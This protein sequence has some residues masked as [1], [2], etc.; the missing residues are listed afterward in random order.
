MTNLTHVVLALAVLALPAL[1]GGLIAAL[2]VVEDVPTA[3][4]SLNA[5]VLYIAFP[6]LIAHAL[7]AE[8]FVMPTSAAFW[9][10]VP[11]AQVFVLACCLAI[12]GG[13]R[14]SVALTGLW[15]NIGY[16]GLPLVLATF[17]EAAAGR[18]AIWASLYIAI[19]VSLG[20]AMLRGGSMSAVRDALKHPLVVSLPVGLLLRLLPGRQVE[21]ADA[22]L[23]PLSASAAPVALFLLGLHIYDRR[24]ELSGITGLW[25]HVGMKLVLAPALTLAVAVGFHL[26]A[27]LSAADIPPLVTLAATPVAIT[28]LVV[29]SEAGRAVTVVASSIFVSSLLA[30]FTLVPWIIFAD[31][32]AGWLVAR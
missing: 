23:A 12:G 13:H 20:P 24:A 28:T 6:A 25:R 18:A 22:F 5:Y 8:A 11:V 14:G 2:R 32:V 4:R 26:W 19:G 9:L 10:V 1:L 15:G 30:V 31:F 16:L 7:I 3:A 21:I 27:G 29:A 17:G